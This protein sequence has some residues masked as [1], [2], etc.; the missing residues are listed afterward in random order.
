[1]KADGAQKTARKFEKEDER[2]AEKI[3]RKDFGEKR[4]SRKRKR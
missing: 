1:M 3:V 2:K 4:I